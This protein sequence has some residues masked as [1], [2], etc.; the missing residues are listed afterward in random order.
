MLKLFNLVLISIIFS[1]MGCYAADKNQA[2]NSNLREY[3]DCPECP[4]MVIL[5]IR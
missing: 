5:P 4:E 3:K 1:V 2:E